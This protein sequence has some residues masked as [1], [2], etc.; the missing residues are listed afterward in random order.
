MKG[1]ILDEETS[2]IISI[3]YTQSKLYKNDIYLIQKIT[4]K[5]EKLLHLK[6]TYFIRPT[7]DN[8]NYLI[9]EIKDP[10]FL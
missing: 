5:T 9:E 6:A 8:I 3:V 7:Q 2:G 4:D 10:R 1:L